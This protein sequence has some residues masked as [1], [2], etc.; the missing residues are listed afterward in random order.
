MADVV[1]VVVVLVA[2]ALFVGLVGLSDRIV[3]SGTQDA[4]TDR[5]GGPANEVVDR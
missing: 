5:G 4:G 1:Y 2:F 3:R